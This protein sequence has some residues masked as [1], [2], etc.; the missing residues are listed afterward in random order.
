MQ[1]RRRN[2]AK[3]CEECRRKR[4]KCDGLKPDCSRCINKMVTCT[5]TLD[6]DRRKLGSKAQLELLRNRVNVLERALE[7]RGIDIEKIVAQ[8]VDE[9]NSE[10]ES[11]RIDSHEDSTFAALGTPPPSEL[12]PGAHTTKTAPASKDPVRVA[13]EG[14]LTVEESL[15]FD[16]DGEVRYFGPS[17]GRLQFEPGESKATD[18]DLEP[19][20]HASGSSTAKEISTRKNQ[21]IESVLED[22]KIPPALQEH[23]LDMYF[24]WEQPW[25]WVV[26]EKLFRMSLADGGRY[27]SPLLLNCI[28]AIASRYTDRIE[29][30]TD[31]SDPNTAGKLFLD[32]AEVLLHY[33]LKWPTITTIQSLS[34]MGTI[35][36]AQGSDAAGWLHQGMANRLAIDMGLNLDVT[37]LKR[38]HTMS[39]EEIDLRREIYWALYC[40]D[41]LSAAYT[42]RVCTFLDFQGVVNLPESNPS[43]KG[44]EH[45]WLFNADE[46]YPL[47]TVRT[48]FTSLHR[49][50]ISLCQILETILLNLYAPKPVCEKQHRTTFRHSC[51]L[52]LKNWYSELPA[53]VRIDGKS[54]S[55]RIPHVFITHMVYH[56]A[57]ILLHKPFLDESRI[58]SETLATERTRHAAVLKAT[59][60][61]YDAAKS[62]CA[63]SQRY[64]ELF[65]T[66]RRSPLTAT[67][68]NLMAALIF[69]RQQDPPRRKKNEAFDAC[70]QVLREL[71]EPWNP[72]GRLLENILKLRNTSRLSQQPLPQVSSDENPD[73]LD[74]ILKDPAD[75]IVH[76][77][78][79][80]G[81]MFQGDWNESM[82]HGV[83]DTLDDTD[84]LSLPWL[85]GEDLNFPFNSLP[86]DYNAFEYMGNS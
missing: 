73:L 29:V 41:K 10:G 2:I 57:I 16:Q 83:G 60:A 43:F 77:S 66:F 78:L 13:L 15:N 67:H 45:E 64:R 28:L 27:C 48:S 65:A 39:A 34:I 51:T 6:T 26:N 14:S 74:T 62:I 46:D 42:G 37:S 33:D 8:A 70:A 31:P 76:E 52:K 72:A 79:E 86:S 40:V 50:I 85:V 1:N 9:E 71:S 69:L 18:S 21:L 49:A 68:C 25:C 80:A 55:I 63:T 32:N 17:S 3:A 11:S 7:T 53:E 4:A 30:R 35:Y 82:S 61:C 24:T 38:D 20:Q 36:V 23:L 22:T 19:H 75:S 54:S 58:G 59:A 56:T 5:Y 47:F 44:R 81:S 12:N 84:M